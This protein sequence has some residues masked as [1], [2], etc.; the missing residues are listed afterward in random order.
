MKSDPSIQTA[1][2]GQAGFFEWQRGGIFIFGIQNST[3]RTHGRWGGREWQFVAGGEPSQ[4]PARPQRA[5][6]RLCEGAAL[7]FPVS[8]CV[9]LVCFVVSSLY[10]PHQTSAD[11][12]SRQLVSPLFLLSLIHHD[13]LSDTSATL[14]R[15]LHDCIGSVDTF[16][17]VISRIASHSRGAS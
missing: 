16:P 4:N 14:L 7:L 2:G 9:G 13:T 1:L 5:R 15:S 12:T 10:V 11:H 6:R 3:R 8:L 17:V